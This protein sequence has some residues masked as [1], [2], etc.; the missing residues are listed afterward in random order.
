MNKIREYILEII[1]VS[2]IAEPVLD[3]IVRLAVKQAE[4]AKKR[5][6]KKKEKKQ[7]DTV[8]IE[9]YLDEA[10]RPIKRHLKK[11]VRRQRSREYKKKRSSI[12]RKQALY[13]RT[14]AY[15]RQQRLYKKKMKF[16]AYRPKKRIYH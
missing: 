14:P 6:K 3:D 2:T 12:K 5:R 1:R 11:S 13:R 16:A 7:E 8:E 10:G 9:N 4:K 15:R